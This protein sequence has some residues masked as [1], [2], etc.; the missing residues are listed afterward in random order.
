MIQQ[1]LRKFALV[2][3]LGI[4]LSGCAVLSSF[5]SPSEKINNHIQ[6]KHFQLAREA[7]IR[8]EPHLSESQ[9][10]AWQ[11]LIADEQ[12]SYINRILIHAK[13][14]WKSQ[15]YG[16]AHRLLAVGLENTGSPKRL[17]KR[18][19]EYDLAIA[20]KQNELDI[21]GKM[22]EAQWLSKEGDRLQRQLQLRNSPSLHLE[23]KRIQARS[24][25][26]G[27]S[28]YR[29]GQ[30]L[31]KTGDRVMAYQVIALAGELGQEDAKHYVTQ[32]NQHQLFKAKRKAQH[33]TQQHHQA[34]SLVLT[35]KTSLLTKL[36][37]A[38]KQ[39][40]LALAT[41][42]MTKLEDEYPHSKQLQKYQL[43][44]AK[45]SEQRVS[46]LFQQGNQ[47]YASGQF[48]EALSVWQDILALQAD[49]VEAQNLLSRTQKVIKNLH[50]LSKP[51]SE[52]LILSRQ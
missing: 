1:C 52:T 39:D 22:N 38:L 31:Q 48:N 43:T 35:T 21:E 36:D 49:N 28:L 46:V 45:A 24:N 12:R 10:V 40:K 19:D 11:T 51:E 15:E 30:K 6:K 50:L 20:K 18:F 16:R 26:L 5:S 29:L 23:L 27:E 32:I 41:A 8:H 25:I 17:Q 7:L 13:Q 47:F 3:S 37:S 4:S 33:L 42:I 44:L 14:L 2:L 9:I 34:Q